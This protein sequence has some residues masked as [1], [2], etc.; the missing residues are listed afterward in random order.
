[1]TAFLISDINN[2]DNER[3]IIADEMRFEDN[4][5][6]LEKKGKIVASLLNVNVEPLPDGGTKKSS[7]VLGK[8]AAKYISFDLLDRM[9]A[10][11]SPEDVNKVSEDIRSLAASVLSQVEHG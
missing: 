11:W 2:P 4:R 6:I 10:P 1:M 3:I 8:L 9:S 7:P 5:L